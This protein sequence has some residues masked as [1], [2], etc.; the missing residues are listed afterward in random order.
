VFWRG[1]NRVTNNL[2][3]E[4]LT[5]RSES[6]IEIRGCRFSVNVNSGSAFVACFYFSFSVRLATTSTG[7]KN[8][9]P[10]SGV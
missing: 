9:R 8:L 7:K 6:Q 1:F 10:D 4:F 2:Y 3:E 5:A